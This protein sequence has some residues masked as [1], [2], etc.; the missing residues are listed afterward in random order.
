MLPLY[1]LYPSSTRTARRFFRAGAPER[2]NHALPSSFFSL[3][4]TPK[5]F[6]MT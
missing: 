5:F 2:A 3:L 6:S 1:S 4:P